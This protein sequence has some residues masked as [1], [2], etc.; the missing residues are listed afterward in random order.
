[1]CC[2]FFD[3]SDYS[4]FMKI[5]NVF[6]SILDLMTLAPYW[7]WFF[8][9]VPFCCEFK[10]SHA[11]CNEFWFRLL[12]RIINS[13]NT[14]R[15]RRFFPS[16]RPFDVGIY[17]KVLIYTILFSFIHSDV[18]FINSL[19]LSAWIIFGYV[20]VSLT[21][22]VKPFG[23]PDAGKDYE[24]LSAT[25][26]KYCSPWPRI[27]KYQIKLKSRPNHSR[28]IGQRDLHHYWSAFEDCSKTLHRL[29]FDG[30]RWWDS[31]RSELFL[32]SVVQ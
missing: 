13:L 16:T 1:M 15:I 30:R 12:F 29:W 10:L 27:R 28:W 22:K 11:I 2:A 5:Y 14:S 31:R 18:S 9:V 32:W 19:P 17:D 7:N 25:A 21:L 26:S 23:S 6:I 4:F 3:L 20:F 8:F 24:A